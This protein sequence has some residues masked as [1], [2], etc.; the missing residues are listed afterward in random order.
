[1]KAYKITV[2]VLDFDEVGEDEIGEMIESA[3]YPNHAIS[4]SVISTEQA[5]IGEWE[6]GHVFN[7]D[8]AKGM[9]QYFGK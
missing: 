1:M 8:I 7:T 4:P 3:R 5:D 9:D 6:D 2:L